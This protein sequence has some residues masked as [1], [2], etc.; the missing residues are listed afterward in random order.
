M[1]LINIRLNLILSII[2]LSTTRLK[3]EELN[4]Y[5]T[6]DENKYEKMVYD[7]EE[8]TFKNLSQL[9]IKEDPLKDE[10]KNDRDLFS[11]N[12]HSFRTESNLSLIITLILSVLTVI[13]SACFIFIA[14]IVSKNI[15]IGQLSYKVINQDVV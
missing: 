8:V 11:K 3:L 12:G 6:T 1:R 2:L 5:S 7:D 14:Y 10:L 4:D 15:K 13:A 9:Q